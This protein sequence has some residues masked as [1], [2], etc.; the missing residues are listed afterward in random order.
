MA[1]QAYIDGEMFYATEK[2]DAGESPVSHPD[3]WRRI[4][5]PEELMRAVALKAASSIKD[6]EGQADKARQLERRAQERLDEQILKAGKGDMR[7]L[8]P[9]VSTR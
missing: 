8:R 5:L 6:S 7:T 2:A 3:Q 1:T 9:H 4:D